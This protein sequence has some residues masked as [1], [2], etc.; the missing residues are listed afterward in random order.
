MKKEKLSL[1]MDTDMQAFNSLVTLP[2][3]FI[4][5]METFS[6]GRDVRALDIQFLVVHCRSVYNYFFR[7]LFATS[8]DVIA[9]TVHLKMKYHNVDDELV[10]FCVDLTIA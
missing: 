6:K 4:E 10:T 8:F 5:L 1:Y 2:W 3:G 9:S 7:I